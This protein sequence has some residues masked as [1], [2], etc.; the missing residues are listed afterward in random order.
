MN[1]NGA[2]SQIKTLAFF[3]LET[4]GIPELENFKTKITE[5]SIVACSTKH[6]LE[7]KSQETPRVLHKLS[8]CFNPC[9]LKLN[10]CL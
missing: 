5:I 8:H 3:D 4:T 1:K 7:T 6:F 2:I 9:N 10:K